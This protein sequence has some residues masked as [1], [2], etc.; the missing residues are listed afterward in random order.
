MHGRK[1]DRRLKGPRVRSCTC[2]RE[3]T[4][5]E[6]YECKACRRTWERAKRTPGFLPTVEMFPE[7]VTEPEP[8]PT[9]LDQLD[10]FT[11]PAWILP[12]RPRSD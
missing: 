11:E 3:L 5:D 1:T 4:D 8:E 7:L 2:G 10:M 9:S 12:G 6:G